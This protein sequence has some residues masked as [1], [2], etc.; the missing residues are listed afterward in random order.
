MSSFAASSSSS[1]SI[2][3]GNDAFNKPITTT[4]Y[5][6]IQYHMNH[7]PSHYLDTT[8]AVYRKVT[9]E[10][11]HKRVS[12]L[13]FQVSQ[14]LEEPFVLPC[15][16]TSFDQPSLNASYRVFYQ[17]GESYLRQLFKGR[18]AAFNEVLIDDD[19]K[20]DDCHDKI[21]SF[22]IQACKKTDERN[23]CI[24][25]C[26]CNPLKTATM[27]ANHTH[28]C[29]DVC[30]QIGFHNR[31][32]VPE[33]YPWR[34]SNRMT[35]WVT[36]Y[37][38]FQF[39]LYLCYTPEIWDA[40][41]GDVFNFTSIKHPIGLYPFLLHVNE[42][43]LWCTLIGN[44]ADSQYENNM[45]V[46]VSPFV[47]L[48]GCSSLHHNFH[49]RVSVIDNGMHIGFVIT[50]AAIAYDFTQRY[51]AHHHQDIDISFNSLFFL[52][53][54]CI[55]NGLTKGYTVDYQDVIDSEK[56]YMG[57][58][59]RDLRQ[60]VANVYALYRAN[61][62]T[63]TL[64]KHSMMTSFNGHDINTLFIN[65]AL[66]QHI[67]TSPQYYQ[68]AREHC[69]ESPLMTTYT[70]L[71]CTKSYIKVNYI[72]GD[73][74]LYHISL[75]VTTL[76]NHYF[77]STR[78]VFK[79]WDVP[80]WFLHEALHHCYYQDHDHHAFHMLPLPATW[81]HQQ[82][83][84]VKPELKDNG[85]FDMIHLHH[86]QLIINNEFLLW[87]NTLQL[88]RYFNCHFRNN[89]SSITIDTTLRCIRPHIQ[90]VCF[91]HDPTINHESVF[92]VYGVWRLMY[93]LHILTEVGDNNTSDDTKVPKMTDAQQVVGV[94]ERCIKQKIIVSK[95]MLWLLLVVR[96]IHTSFEFDNEH[97][98]NTC[99]K[100][101]HYKIPEV[102]PPAFILKDEDTDGE[103]CWKLIQ[104]Q[105]VK[106][107]VGKV[108]YRLNHPPNW[109]TLSIEKPVTIPVDAIKLRAK[110][111]SLY[112]DPNQ[113]IT[114]INFFWKGC[115][116]HLPWSQKVNYTFF[117]S[118]TSSSSSDD[119]DI[120]WQ[121]RYTEDHTSHIIT[122]VDAKYDYLD[123]DLDVMPPDSHFLAMANQRLYIII[124]DLFQDSRFPVRLHEMD[125]SL[126]LNDYHKHTI[127]HMKT[128]TKMITSRKYMPLVYREDYQTTLHHI[129][130]MES[131]VHPGDPITSLTRYLVALGVEK[132]HTTLR[133]Y[134]DKKQTS[135]VQS[136]A[137]RC[138]DADAEQ[139]HKHHANLVQQ[140][141]NKHH[142]PHSS[143]QQ[144][145]Q[146]K[147]KRSNSATPQFNQ[148]MTHA[149]FH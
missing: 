47:N 89:K 61:T 113:D 109:S 65:M 35:V 75:K 110:I 134:Y 53:Y 88:L 85:E 97:Q 14:W 46:K 44:H 115:S 63:C 130:F 132:E 99:R 36:P 94:L 129:L 21:L 31:E 54:Y 149:G 83:F 68:S 137:K 104:Q 81:S 51:L 27:F 140:Q 101:F 12:L 95:S 50:T 90:Q 142:Q 121:S 71:P 26:Q 20:G 18:G 123:L 70:M 32:Y 119:N 64:E 114:K 17:F 57:V 10:L 56:P 84:Q 60:L 33:S 92:S 126:L 131:Y 6:L 133:E 82:F 24:I 87:F 52:S 15:P 30:K 116:V 13:P 120:S 7:L 107:M 96:S 136:C 106:L 128:I 118:S 58:L 69:I 146:F 29:M 103:A 72:C 86:T 66:L 111:L 138:A 100:G 91:T 25:L 42:R 37:E 45:Q 93:I 79:I 125:N 141:Q 127:E 80:A 23:V 67:D 73:W 117:S 145:Q 11:L 43:P 74:F 22:N 41:K 40:F 122:P 143:Q 77:A 76:Q 124:E 135:Y 139:R 147:H 48:L 62:E 28:K 49:A 59:R 5:K 78:T 108:I 19:S 98:Y 102:T 38:K 144:Q 9:D 148:L 39:L 55:S 1:S 112:L 8:P 2:Y 3:N 4:V 34:K 16:P 105:K